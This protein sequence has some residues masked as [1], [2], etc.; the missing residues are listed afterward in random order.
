MYLALLSQNDIH[1]IVLEECQI[2]T[3]LGKVCEVPPVE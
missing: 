1:F 3:Q 2:I